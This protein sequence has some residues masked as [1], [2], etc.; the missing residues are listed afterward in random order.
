MDQSDCSIC[1][2]GITMSNDVSNIVEV[3]T[4]S[5][6]IRLLDQYG[7]RYQNTGIKTPTEM[8]YS[9]PD[10]YQCLLYHCTDYEKTVGANCEKTDKINL[11]LPEH[12]CS[13]DQVSI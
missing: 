13:L 9:P 11:A 3:S 5:K 4:L 10:R 2:M 6:I 1:L 8:P 12:I 7:H